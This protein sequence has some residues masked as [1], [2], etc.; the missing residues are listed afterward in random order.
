[1]AQE[2]VQTCGLEQRAADRYGDR[3]DGLDDT[4]RCGDRRDG[5]DGT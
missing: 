3:R 4:F 5:L 1:M 2:R